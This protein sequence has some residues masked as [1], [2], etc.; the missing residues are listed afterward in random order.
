MHPLNVSQT[1]SFRL[2]HYIK[3]T[4]LTAWSDWMP[5]FQL[6]IQIKKIK[7][8]TDASMSNNILHQ[9]ILRRIN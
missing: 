4:E 9:I 1:V 7:M 8:L 2:G 3:I 6:K 5:V